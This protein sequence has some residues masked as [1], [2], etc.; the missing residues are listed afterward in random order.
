[1]T[2]INLR[3][4]YPFYTQD[5]FVEVS[6]ELAAEMEQWER[7]ERSLRRK[8]YLYRAQYSLDRDDGM[9]NHVLFGLE[10]PEDHYVEEATKEQLETALLY[11]SRKQAKRIYDYYYLW[12]SKTEIARKEGV[13][14][15]TIG[16]SISYGLKNPGKYLKDFY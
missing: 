8:K 9:E 4:Y 5:E 13:G 7:S 11:L 3:T 16:K 2:T 6:D 14:K 1:M 10:S 12:Q 15:A